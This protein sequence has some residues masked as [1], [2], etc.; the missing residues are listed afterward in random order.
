MSGFYKGDFFTGKCLIEFK[1]P[2]TGKR[3]F[4]GIL[5]YEEDG[6]RKQKTKVFPREIKTKSTADNALDQ[7]KAEMESKHAA[8]EASLPVSEYVSNYL[9]TQETLKTLEASTISGYR[10]IEKRIASRF[11]G[12]ALSDLEPP[13]VQKWV[14]SLLDAGLSPSTAAKSLK[15]LSQVCKHA[16]KSRVLT[17]NPCDPVKPPKVSYS[18]PCAL[19]RDGREKLVRKLDALEPTAFVTAAYIALFTGMRQGE[20]C[21]LQWRSVDLDNGEIHVTQAVGNGRGGAYLKETKSRAGVRTIP[22]PSQVVEALHR[23]KVSQRAEWDR[24]RLA[25]GMPATDSDFDSVFVVGTSDPDSSFKNPNLLGKEWH[26]F[27]LDNGIKDSRG[28]VLK[29]HG[30]RDTYATVA[31]TGGADIVSVAAN[32]GHGD[33]SMTLNK[34]AS[35]NKEGQRRA[36]NTVENEMKPR[37][38][39]KVTPLKPTGTEGGAV[40]DAF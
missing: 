1:D 7:W 27:A 22:L 6:K 39:A 24:Y 34:Y 26:R 21:G 2:K 16:V 12:T 33:K 17:W 9:S 4:R 25:A 32:L 15:L 40:G 19:D 36:A 29:F 28:H 38:P 14:K 30:L 13:D 11:S 8:P 37:K 23:R 5:T 18:E 10:T 20:I 35:A 31:I 3:R